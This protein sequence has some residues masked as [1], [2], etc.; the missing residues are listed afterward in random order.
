VARKLSFKAFVK[1]AEYDA[2]IA[3]WYAKEMER[4]E[5][6]DKIGECSNP[7]LLRYGENPHQR[8]CIYSDGSKYGVANAKQHH[9]K[10]LSYN[11]YLDLEAAYRAAFC[12][13]DDNEVC[14]IIKHTNTCGLAASPHQ[15][16]AFRFALACDP[17][18]AFGSVICF[19]DVVSPATALAIVESKLFIECIIAPGYQDG[20]LKTLHKKNKQLRLLEVPLVPAR[21]KFHMHKVSGGMLVQES[22]DLRDGEWKRVTEAGTDDIAIQ[23]DLKFAWKAV[24]N[25]KSNA[26]VIVKNKQLIGMGTG[27]PNRVDALKQAAEKA[28]RFGFSCEGA[29]MA[30][31][32]FFPFNDCV[33]EASALGIFAI[34]QPGGSKKDQDSIDACNEAGIVMYFTGV[35]HFRH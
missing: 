29:V 9:G 32:A 6:P 28:N 16:D 13:D 22:D 33:E 7:K 11:N 4:A 2:A 27:Q 23:E 21:P 8:A 14:A 17:V 35:R 26:I 19:N 10:E 3:D 24:A 5:F 1:T 31:D 15:S 34:V 18:S 12:F 30:S 25:L 20:V